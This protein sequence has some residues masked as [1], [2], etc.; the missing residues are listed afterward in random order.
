VYFKLLHLFNLVRSGHTKQTE[1]PKKKRPLRRRRREW[2]DR[3][4]ID[5]KETESDVVDW[6]NMLKS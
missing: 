5:V 1:N 4:K 6:S 2:E 3:I